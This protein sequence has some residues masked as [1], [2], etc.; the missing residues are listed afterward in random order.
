M[1]K[2]VILL[3]LIST[4]TVSSQDW[5]NKDS[6]ELFEM[7][8]DEAFNGN[9]VKARE[10]L[11]YL[12]D[13]SPNYADVRILLGRTYAWDGDRERAK[14]A[15]KRVLESDPDNQDALNALID[16]QM[17]GDEY[18]SALSTANI[19]IKY[20]PT[21]EDYIYKKASSLAS[22]ER[23]EEANATLNQLLEIN[24]AHEK[25][26]A[27]RKSIKESQLRYSL[28]VRLGADFFSRNFDPAY[29]GSMQLSRN[30]DWGSSIGRINYSRRFNEAGIQGEVDLYPIIKKGV[31]GYLNYGFSKS[32]LFPDH[33]FGAE[34]FSKLP[35]SFEGS[36]GL[37][38][39]IFAPTSFTIYTG[40]LGW[41]YKSMWL[42]A[43]PFITPDKNA[44]TSFSIGLTAR[45]YF[46]N[47]ST[48]L[49]FSGG[50]GYSPDIRTIQ[51]G[52]GLATDEIFTLKA[53]RF[54]IGFNKLLKYNWIASL[55]TN[56]VHQELTFDLGNYVWITSIIGN[57]TYRF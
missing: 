53:Q 22:L 41:Y 40:S 5:K 31:Y 14:K 36:L 9:R 2:I 4:F 7:A 55:D 13:K 18:K 38:H 43:R 35:K 6:D 30:N 8:R 25:G 37:R 23:F 42:S 3:L 56:F 52:Q 45:R 15:F 16:V 20:Y 17:W 44:G 33:R 50:F 48:F 32:S 49:E 10:M 27:L 26:L 57:I 51:S 11:I 24:P 54:G 12:L 29:Y 21:F 47:P 34:V 19:G 46:N 28:N 1:K 39:L